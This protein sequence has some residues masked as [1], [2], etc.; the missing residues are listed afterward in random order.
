MLR[1]AKTASIHL[2]I[3]DIVVEFRKFLYARAHDNKQH[4]IDPQYCWG[5]FLKVTCSDWLKGH[6]IM[7]RFQT[8]VHN[9]QNNFAET[10]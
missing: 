2:E 10:W 5:E 6:A 7:I 9:K 3:E 8:L 4:Q 1:L